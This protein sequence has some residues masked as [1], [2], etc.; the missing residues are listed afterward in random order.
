MTTQK[1]LNYRKSLTTKKELFDSENQREFIHTF[2]P[3]FFNTSFDKNQLKTLIAW[4]LNSYGEKITVDLLETLKEI[5]F[6]QATLAGVSLGIDDL[7]I[8]AQ[9]PFL[10]SQALVQIQQKKEISQVSKNHNV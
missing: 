1:V 9:K 3:V 4:F 5:G 8:P 10:I 6:H 2:Q 7:L